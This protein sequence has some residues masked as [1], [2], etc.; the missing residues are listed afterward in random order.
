MQKCFLMVALTLV[1][2]G[3]WGN[4]SC[5]RGSEAVC[6]DP[7]DLVC[8]AT[9]KCVNDQ[10]VCFEDYPCD[11]DDGFVCESRHDELANENE[12]LVKK[13]NQLISEHNDLI[14]RHSEKERC[15]IK[16]A[17]LESAKKCVL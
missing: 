13:Y 1:C 16:A 9:S 10:A 12:V 7:G 3:A 17:T 15:V 5:P 14:G 2:V 4:F 11:A 6:L 8:P